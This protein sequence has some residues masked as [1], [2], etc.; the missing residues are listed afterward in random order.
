MEGW[1]LIKVISKGVRSSLGIYISDEVRDC[2]CHEFAN[3]FP[4]PCMSSLR[5]LGE[6]VTLF[7]LLRAIACWFKR[8]PRFVGFIVDQ[9]FCCGLRMLSFFV[10]EGSGEMWT[11]HQAF[12][13]AGRSGTL[14]SSIS[15]VLYESGIFMSS[16]SWERFCFL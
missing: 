9:W 16:W 3:L 12:Q 14:I 13:K 8:T 15:I 5:I 11:I 6:G 4:D 10:L 7:Q 1:C 2:V